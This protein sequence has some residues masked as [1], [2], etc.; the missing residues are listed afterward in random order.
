MAWD[1]ADWGGR[2]HRYLNILVVWE[3]CMLSANLQLLHLKPNEDIKCRTAKCNTDMILVINEMNWTRRF[4][5]NMSI[6]WNISEIIERNAWNH[7]G[8]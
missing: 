1:Y 8:K 6:R 3:I 2:T 4:S 7:C 5:F